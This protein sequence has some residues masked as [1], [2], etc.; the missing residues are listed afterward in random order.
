MSNTTQRGFGHLPCP[1]CGEVTTIKMD[2]DDCFT[3]TCS[4]CEGEFTTDDVREFIA[5]WVPLLK[6]IETA[7]PI[8]K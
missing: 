6:W 4:E 8:G 5:A 1:K 7:P 3:M 2:L